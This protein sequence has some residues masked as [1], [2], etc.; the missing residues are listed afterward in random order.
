MIQDVTSGTRIKRLYYI[1]AE[2]T[3]VLSTSF[4]KLLFLLDALHK[5]SK[6][7]NFVMI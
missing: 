7:A 1:L 6:F 4:R 5:R 3:T 2:A